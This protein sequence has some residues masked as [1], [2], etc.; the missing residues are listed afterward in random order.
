MLS[1]DRRSHVICHVMIPWFLGAPKSFAF[2][3]IMNMGLIDSTPQVD[4][5]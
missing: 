5:N 2:G 3:E 1:I 4:L